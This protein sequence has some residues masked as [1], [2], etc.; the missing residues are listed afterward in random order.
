VNPIFQGLV[1]LA[2]SFLVAATAVAYDRGA[3]LRWREALGRTLPRFGPMSNLW[4]SKAKRIARL[5]RE[6]RILK[7]E[8]EDR[9]RAHEFAIRRAIR[10]EWER[11]QLKLKAVYSAKRWSGFTQ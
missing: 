9:L 11:D 5:E 2:F 3:P 7:A 8:S 10:A 4:G 6:N 1:W